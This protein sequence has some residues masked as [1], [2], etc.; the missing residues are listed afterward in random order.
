M[1]RV[2]EKDEGSKEI[3]CGID[4]HGRSL[5][6]GMAGALMAPNMPGDLWVT[7]LPERT[8]AKSGG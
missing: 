7:R 3:F 2:T 4:L 1:N 6:T 8:P 5:S